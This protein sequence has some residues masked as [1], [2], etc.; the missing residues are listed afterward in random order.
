M[1]VGPIE[2][3]V[4]RC[5]QHK[6]TKPD[7]ILGLYLRLNDD[8]IGFRWMPWTPWLLGR[9]SEALKLVAISQT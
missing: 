5:Y 3:G 1:V 2:A 4:R 9:E 7:K 8:E 6:T